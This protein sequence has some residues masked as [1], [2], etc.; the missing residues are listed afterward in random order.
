[1]AGKTPMMQINTPTV[2]SMPLAIPAKSQAMM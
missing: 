2:L 1:M